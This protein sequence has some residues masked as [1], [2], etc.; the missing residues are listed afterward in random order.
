M[1]LDSMCLNLDTDGIDLL[2]QLLNMD[3]NQRITCE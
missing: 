3:W 1:N 2:G